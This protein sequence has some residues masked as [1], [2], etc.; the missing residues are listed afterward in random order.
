MWDVNNDGYPEA[1]LLRRGG[2][3][4]QA[5]RMY[6]P[7]SALSVLCTCRCAALR[8][9]CVVVHASQHDVNIHKYVAGGV[10]VIDLRKVHLFTLLIIPLYMFSR[11]S[12]AVSSSSDGRRTVLWSE[13]LDLTADHRSACIHSL[14]SHIIVGT[15]LC[16]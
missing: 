9:L 2:I 15:S 14:R 3:Q 8:V 7:I 11:S 4:Q 10:V 5:M 13:H 6:L 16:T 12:L 1:V